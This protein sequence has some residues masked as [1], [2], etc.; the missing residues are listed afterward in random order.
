MTFFIFIL[1]CSFLLGSCQNAD[2]KDYYKISSFQI[3]SLKD[4]KKVL[5]SN[6][7]PVDVQ[8]IPLES[9]SLSSIRDIEDVKF[10]R[11]FILIKSFN[12]I[13][14]FRNNG[15]FL[16]QIGKSGRGPN[17]FLIAHDFDID[18]N[19]GNIYLVD[20]WAKKFY[21]YSENGK[22]IKSFSSPPNT[23]NF[24]II[25][26]GILCYSTNYISNIQF[27]YNLI[28]TSGKI[29]K[30]FPNKYLWSYDVRKGTAVFEENIFFQLNNKLFKKEV[31]SDT[32][33]VFEDLMFKPYLVIDHGDKLLTPKARSEYTPLYLK[34]NFI[35]QKNIFG[36][37]NFIYYEFICNRG[38][39]FGLLCSVKSDS[40]QIIE[41][42][43]GLINDID[44]GPDI[45]PKTVKD[46]NTLV[47]WI[48]V[49]ELKEYI[50]SEIFRK[51]EPKFPEKKRKLEYLANN[52]NETDNPVL[53][54]VHVKK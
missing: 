28:D 5:L 12:T 37:G 46:D 25:K 35:S 33:Y 8:Y 32:V 6:L 48:E 31:Y 19:T 16:T 14:K 49:P 27:S 44:C 15:T 54:I 10:G 18:R 50:A 47:S 22:F 52:L 30:K 36:V 3:N 7:S 53:I 43:R 23:I 2:I 13:L 24:K 41:P 40:S 29:I 9:S 39:L 1:L 20:G 4:F 42:E 26:E 45:W 11:D 34:E 51:S 38:E 21:I 17:E